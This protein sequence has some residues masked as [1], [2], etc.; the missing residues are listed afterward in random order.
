MRDC[1]ALIAAGDA[2]VATACIA[3][4]ISMS[5]R[6]NEA[7]QLLKGELSRAKATDTR[8]AWAL[9]IL[10]ELAERKGDYE[11]AERSMERAIVA[12]PVNAAL[13]VQAADLL[14]R[15]KR[16]DR[17]PVVLAR[18]PRREPVVLRYA[19]AAQC[20]GA[21][22]ADALVREWRELVSFDE[23]LGT[24]RHYRDAAVGELRLLGRAA[25]A[26]RYAKLNWEESKEIEDARVLLTAARAAGDLQAA[27]PMLRWVDALAIED[28]A[29]D[30][31]RAGLDL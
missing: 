14:L 20:S 24:S 12:D 30:R 9:A 8:I 23:R 6:L 17:V 25:E 11:E 21:T 28:V 16:C 19:I 5:G 13:R 18:L 10:S 1:S 27:S 26:L 29:L 2:L 31:L 3:Q 4:S 15:M 7:Y 22:T